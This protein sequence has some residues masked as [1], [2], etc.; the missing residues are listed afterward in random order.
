[1]R[2]GKQCPGVLPAARAR[3]APF[4]CRSAMARTC[5]TVKL[6]VAVMVIPSATQSSSTSRA[7]AVA[8]SFT[9]MLGA[10]VR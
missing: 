7:A 8:G 5:G 9:A 3:A 6:T 1:M 2:T 10:Q 4:L